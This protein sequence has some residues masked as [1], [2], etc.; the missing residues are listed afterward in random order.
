MGGAASPARELGL[1]QRIG[2]MEEAHWN[3]PPGGLGR[4]MDSLPCP[5]TAQST[6]AE[7]LALR[8]CHEV[9]F[10]LGEQGGSNLADVSLCVSISIVCDHKNSGPLSNAYNAPRSTMYVLIGTVVPK[11]CEIDLILILIS[12]TTN[13]KYR[14]L[15]NCPRS[16]K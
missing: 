14:H 5:P 16:Q 8:K 4:I 2:V 1:V 6:M 12:C 15:R 7:P 9:W 11:P 13:V 3:P 10:S